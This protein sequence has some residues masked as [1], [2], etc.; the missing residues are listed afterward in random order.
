[1]LTVDLYSTNRLLF[2]VAFI[3]IHNVVAVSLV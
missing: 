2:T 3:V 1:M